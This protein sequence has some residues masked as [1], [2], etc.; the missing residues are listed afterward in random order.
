M[1]MP[2]LSHEP[3]AGDHRRK[4]KGRF[5]RVAVPAMVAVAAVALGWLV[6]QLYLAALV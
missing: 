5:V 4:G 3:G 2:Y 6:M 1:T